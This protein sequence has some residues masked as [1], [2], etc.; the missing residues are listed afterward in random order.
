MLNITKVNNSVKFE[1]LDN[2]QFPDNGVLTVPLNSLILVVEDN[3]DMVT[4]RSVANNNVYCSGLIRNIRIAGSTVTKESIITQFDAVANSSSGGGGGGGDYD[5]TEIR[6]MI[7]NESAARAQ[8]DE[9]LQTQI[10]TV[11]DDA[12]SA[13]VSGTTLIINNLA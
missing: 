2:K 1:G 6:Q 5:D 4:F 10:N 9:N 7:A 11:N 12:V 13:Q 8:A 3:S